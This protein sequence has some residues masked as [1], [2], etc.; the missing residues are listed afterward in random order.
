ML[1]GVTWIYLRGVDGMEGWMPISD[2]IY[3]TEGNGWMW[4]E[5]FSVV[6]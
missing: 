5:V 4:Y 1:N 3:D 2:G 6:E